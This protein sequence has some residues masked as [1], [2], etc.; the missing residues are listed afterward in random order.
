MQSRKLV[1]YTPTTLCEEAKLECSPLVVKKKLNIIKNILES[2]H[3]IKFSS[4][5]AEKVR[6][7]VLERVLD[8]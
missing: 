1:Q 8:N 7:I 4:K 3:S 6:L 2:E 5:R